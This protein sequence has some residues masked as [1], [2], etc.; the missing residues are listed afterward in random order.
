M[1]LFSVVVIHYQGAIPREIFARGIESLQKQTFKDFELL[2]Y[3]DRPLLHPD[4][5]QPLPIRCTEKRF[6]DTGHS[7]R[8]I[9]MREARGEYIVLFNADNILYPNAL[10]T[11]AAEI[12]RAP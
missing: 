9:G 5:P 3:P 12:R 10:E 6:N 8:D 4:A 11:I 7:L 1:P 2:C